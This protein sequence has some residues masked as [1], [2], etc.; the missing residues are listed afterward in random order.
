M[1]P[2]VCPCVCPGVSFQLDTPEKPGL[3]IPEGINMHAGEKKTPRYFGQGKH[4]PAPAGNQTWRVRLL[5]TGWWSGLPPWAQPNPAQMS[6]LG[7][8]PL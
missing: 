3:G 4:T 2:L 8:R 6:H 7:R 1:I 5:V